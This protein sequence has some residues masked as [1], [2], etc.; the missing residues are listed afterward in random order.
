[1]C[2]S[3]GSLVHKEAVFTESMR[4]RGRASVI[5]KPGASVKDA[6]SIRILCEWS[7]KNTRLPEQ[8]LVLPRSH[9]SEQP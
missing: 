8:C 3:A 2:L 4:N 5:S 7:T 9:C 1:M 6:P